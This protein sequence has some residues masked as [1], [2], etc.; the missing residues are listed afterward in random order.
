MQA[1][2]RARHQ[3]PPR[4]HERAPGTGLRGGGRGSLPNSEAAR[5]SVI[6]LPLHTQMTDDDQDY[7]IDALRTLVGGDR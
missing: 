3:H 4:D 2:A 5:D 6:L 7:V 1:L